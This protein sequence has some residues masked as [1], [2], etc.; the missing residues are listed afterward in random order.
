[1]RRMREKGKGDLIQMRDNEIIAK[2][3][4]NFSLRSFFASRKA[5]LGAIGILLLR[6]IDFRAR[7]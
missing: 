2:G 3:A 1:M 6:V 7:I 5:M 4:E